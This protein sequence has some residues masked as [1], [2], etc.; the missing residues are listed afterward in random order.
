MTPDMRYVAPLERSSRATTVGGTNLRVKQLLLDS[1]VNFSS[2]AA[3]ISDEHSWGRLRIHARWIRF[4]GISTW[5]C[6]SG[7]RRPR[8]R[9]RERVRGKKRHRHPKL[10][11]WVRHLEHEGLPVLKNKR[12]VQIT[13][14][15][16][17]LQTPLQKKLWSKLL[18]SWFVFC[19]FCFGVVKI[20]KR[21]FS[22][23]KTNCPVTAKL[24]WNKRGTKRY[25]IYQLY[26]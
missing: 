14:S 19:F 26:C 15:Q 2:G 21:K 17:V 8:C 13:N 12:Q 23:V 16:N 11:E 5:A 9:T 25:V 4:I 1:R 22:V 10:S 7:C 24:S 20:K 3:S 18:E 6:R